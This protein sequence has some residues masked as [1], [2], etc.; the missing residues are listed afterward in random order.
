[1]MKMIKEKVALEVEV[2]LG[3][4]IQPTSLHVQLTNGK[5]GTLSNLAELDGYLFCVG[6][7]EISKRLWSP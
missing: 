1:M 7:L 4:L 2:A 3:W 6:Y 5:K